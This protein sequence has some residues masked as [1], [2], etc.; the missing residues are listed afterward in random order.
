LAGPGRSRGVPKNPLSC[1]ERAL[2]LLAVRPRSRRELRSRL[3]R[4]GFEP[5]EVEDELARLE[6]VGLVDDEA[7]AHQAVEHELTVRRS[8]RRAIVSRL[9]ARGLDR[10]TME[11]ALEDLVTEDEDVRATELAR[12]RAG[13]LSG[14]PPERAFARLVSFLARRGYGP[15]TARRAARTALGTGEPG[16]RAGGGHGT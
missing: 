7:Y 14:I 15:E 3:L 4:A 1:H 12:T 5:D 13:R 11:R 8:G 2:R 16:R 10:E 6:S 9:G